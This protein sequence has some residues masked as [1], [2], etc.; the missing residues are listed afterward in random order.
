MCVCVCVCVCVYE[1]PTLARPLCLALRCSFRSSTSG[2]GV[3]GALR[4][5]P[6]TAGEAI[7]SAA[8]EAI[9]FH[10]ALE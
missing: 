7:A 8:L 10:T 9:C 4:P 5:G 3:M 2:R 1:G 6:L